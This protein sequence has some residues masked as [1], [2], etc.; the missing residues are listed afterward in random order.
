MYDLRKSSEPSSTAIKHFFVLLLLLRMLY[1]TVDVFILV[2]FQALLTS[3][4]QRTSQS[5]SVWFDNCYKRKLDSLGYGDS[6]D[7]EMTETAVVE[8]CKQLY[9]WLRARTKAKIYIWGHSLGAS[10]ALRTAAELSTE[11]IVPTAVILEAAFTTMREEIPVHP[12][13]QVIK[14]FKFKHLFY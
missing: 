6:S 7:G 11:N 1:C 12:Y 2:D 14:R 9:R 5:S 10:L 13:G 4:R 3:I 8:D